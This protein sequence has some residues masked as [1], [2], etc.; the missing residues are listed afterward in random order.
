MMRKGPR[1]KDPSKLFR[2][3]WN[4]AK[5]K[6][7]VNLIK[8]LSDSYC[9]RT[10]PLIRKDIPVLQDSYLA[11]SVTLDRSLQVLQ[12]ICLRLII[13]MNS[14]KVAQEEF[15]FRSVCIKIMFLGSRVA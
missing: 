2:S 13:I 5:P 9:C 8:I 15:K 10:F 4:V 7:K 3:F 11:Y 12:G 14:S 1:L 6:S